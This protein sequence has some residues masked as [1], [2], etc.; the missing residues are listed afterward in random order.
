MGKY[1][2]LVDAAK[3]LMFQIECHQAE[4]AKMA[5]EACDIQRGGDH[6]ERKYSL[7]DFA[8]DAGIPYGALKS[9]VGIYR[10]VFVKIGKPEPTKQEWSNGSRTY[11]SMRSLSPDDTG[12][13]RNYKTNLPKEKVEK[14]YDEVSSNP[15][16]S[17]AAHQ[18]LKYAHMIKS[19]LGK[20][21][22]GTQNAALLSQIV[23][24]LIPVTSKITDHLT[25]GKRGRTA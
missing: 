19:L 13:G 2:E 3:K 4:I 18:A 7:Q 10:D 16:E 21:D 14:L 23:N 6:G 5:M 1:Q 17:L 25:V 15:E 11:A 24:T 8:N 20:V 12:K 9:W 22:M